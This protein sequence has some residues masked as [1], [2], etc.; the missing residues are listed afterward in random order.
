MQRANGKRAVVTGPFD[1]HRDSHAVFRAHAA[2]AKP[3]TSQD[4]DGDG[5]SPRITAE[6]FLPKKVRNLGLG[7]PNKTGVSFPESPQQAGDPLQELSKSNHQETRH[8]GGSGISSLVSTYR[9]EQWKSKKEAALMGWPG[10]IHALRSDPSFDVTV[11]VFIFSSLILAAIEHEFAP[12]NTVVLAFAWILIV[13]FIVELFIRA[14][15]DAHPFRSVLYV[16]ECCLAIV[17]FIHMIQ[18]SSSSSSYAF[19]SLFGFRLA[20]LT[21]I[22]SKGKSFVRLRTLQV[23]TEASR[24]SLQPIGFALLLTCLFVFL[25]AL[26]LMT[27]VPRV[28]GQDEELVRRVVDS[29]ATIGGG[30]TSLLEAMAGVSTWGPDIATPLFD[31][32]D[33]ECQA[34]AATMVVVIL[35]L[36][37]GIGGLI[38]GVFL[39][40]L[41]GASRLHLEADWQKEVQQ[42]DEFLSDFDT[43]FSGSGYTFDDHIS[44][45][46]FKTFLKEKDTNTEEFLG[47]AESTAEALFIHLSVETE[48][49]G[50]LVPIGDFIFGVFKLRTVSK[51]VDMLSIDHQ[52]EKALQ[53]MA[54]M[55]QKLTMN[56]SSVQQ[57]LKSI[58]DRLPELETELNQLKS[59]LE[60][61]QQLEEK[62]TQMGRPKTEHWGGTDEDKGLQFAQKS[63]EELRSDYELNWRLRDLE[64]A[65]AQMQRNFGAEPI[66]VLRPEGDSDREARDEG[67]TRPADLERAP[68]PPSSAPEEAIRMIAMEMMNRVKSMLEA[69]LMD[70]RAKS[71]TPLTT[72]K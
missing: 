22:V 28:E 15:A 64:D 24:M 3:K 63:I 9:P 54:V 43:F 21:R 2:K 61:V 12:D 38:T 13:A 47:I 56:L 34:F 23:L 20:R 44:W 30:M 59:G 72:N 55:R 36:R 48:S 51:S 62:L 68:A 5:A 31:T 35:A 25:F 71:L 8:R 53:R 10:R 27:L 18:W 4:D 42:N 67:G 66:D 57:R 65:V 39:D 45:D 11:V 37:I 49:G 16:F 50:G 29:Y 46:Q 1:A 33:F 69:E 40:T 7:R 70:A 17:I 58:S 32:N 19:V 26:M 41:F 14:F 52:Q 6:A 60:S